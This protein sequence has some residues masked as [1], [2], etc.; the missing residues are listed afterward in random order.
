MNSFADFDLHPEL[1]L[2]LQALDFTL[3]TPIQKQAIPMA[4]QGLDLIAGAQ[5]GSGKTVAFAIPILQRLLNKP[6]AV[7]LILVPTRELAEQVSE[8]F[9]DLL[10]FSPQMRVANLIGGLSMRPQV[11]LLTLKPQVIVAT[12]GRMMDHLRRKNVKLGKL[13]VLVLDEADR[14]LDMGFADQLNEIL[15]FLPEQRQTLLFSATLPKHIMELSGRYLKNP[16]RVQVQ[17]TQETRPQIEQQSLEVPNA[18]KNETLLEQ[19]GQREGSILVFARTQI[20]TTRIVKYLKEYGFHCAVIH[21]GRTQG[22]RKEALDRFRQGSVRV[23]IATDIAARGLDISHVAHV[24]NYDLPQDPAD[25]VHRI[26]RTARAGRS[27]TAM[28]FV[29]PEEKRIWEKIS[30][31]FQPQKPRESGHKGFR[32]LKKPAY[33]VIEDLKV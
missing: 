23:L 10:K 13:E 32:T 28:S 26:G 27:G 31:Q 8:V 33:E 18:R 3:P 22:Q 30:R 21:G 5:T 9:K 29:T 14:M 19:V 11:Q 15:S 20:R 17:S 12:P 4:L 1:K 24:I 7:A 6:E 16:Q 2:S 25:Y